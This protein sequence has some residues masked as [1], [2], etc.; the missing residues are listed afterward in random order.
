M[1]C[2]RGCAQVQ[3][4]VVGIT[5]PQTF[6]APAP[7][8]TPTPAAAAAGFVAVKAG[9]KLPLPAS[10]FRPLQLLVA[11]Q[12]AGQ[13]YMPVT[14]AHTSRGCPPVAW[15]L[16]KV[17]FP[18]QEAWV[19]ERQQQ[20]QQEGASSSSRPPAPRVPLTP[21]PSTA[22]DLLSAWPFASTGQCGW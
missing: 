3:T 16:P 21:G 5:D 7:G 6:P 18:G 1:L 4:L 19:E 20:Q 22:A 17:L 13:P 11:M 14:L 10:F 2:L 9:L 15:C 12:A 8:T